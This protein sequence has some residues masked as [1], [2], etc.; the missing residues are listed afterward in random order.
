MIIDKQGD[1]MDAEELIIATDV[2]CMG[3]SNTG[4]P[5]VL[6]VTYPNVY[7]SYLAA[8]MTI[9]EKNLGNCLCLVSDDKTH[10]VAYLFNRTDNIDQDQQEQYDALE[11][12]L[13][14]LHDIAVYNKDSV[15][16][17]SEFG[18]GNPETVRN[19]IESVFSDYEI[20]IY[21]NEEEE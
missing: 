17:D 19:I 15:A 9:K 6:K 4:L 21:H 3:L 14:Q 1:I 2:S 20:T 12:A 11:H 16:I 8:A 13:K 7:N 18:T 10:V 5:F